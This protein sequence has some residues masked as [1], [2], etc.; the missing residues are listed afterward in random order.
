MPYVLF[1]EVHWYLA[2]HFEE[3]KHQTALLL[4]WKE[5]VGQGSDQKDTPQHLKCSLTKRIFVEPVK[6]K[7]GTVYECKAIEEHLKT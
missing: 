1:L 7:Y 2:S 5:L 6:T 3:I 4:P